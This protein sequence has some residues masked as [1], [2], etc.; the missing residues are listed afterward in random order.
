[1]IRIRRSDE[2]GHADH[3]WLDAR[4]TFSFAG[5]FDPDHMGFRSLRVL[6][7]DS[8]Q[9]GGGFPEHGHD[10]M[11]IVTYVLEGAL[12]HRDSTGRAETLRPGEFQYMSAGTGI[13]HSEFN[14]SKDELVHLLQIWIQP[15]ERDTQP[16]YEQRPFPVEPDVFQRIDLPIGQDV[17]LYRATLGGE[18]ALR[19]ELDGGRGAWL[20]VTRGELALN[21]TELRAGDGAA[22]EEEPVLEVTGGPAEALLFDLA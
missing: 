20:Q 6:N 3:G 18:A 21:G 17:R 16:R 12:A 10:N 8:V 2:R 7:E 5:Y 19:H 1:M 13:R 14:P 9:P 11:E 22:I 4:H 15:A